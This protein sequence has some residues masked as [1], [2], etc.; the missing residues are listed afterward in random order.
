MCAPQTTTPG[1]RQASP[2]AFSRHLW[3][4]TPHEHRRAAEN[5]PAHR[6]LEPARPRRLPHRRRPTRASRQ[7]LPRPR[8]AGPDAGGRGRHRGPGSAHDLRFPRRARKRRQPRH[9]RRRVRGKTADRTQRRRQPEGHSAHRHCQRPRLARRNAGIAARSLPGLRPAKFRP[10]P[11][12]VRIAG[13]ISSNGSPLALTGI[14]NAFANAANLVD[15]AHAPAVTARSAPLGGNGTVPTQLI[16]SLANSI[17]ACVN[18]AGSTF[19]QCSTLFAN[20]KD[21]AGNPPTDTAAAAINIAHAPGAN[22]STIF[23]LSGPIGTPFTP[24]LGATPPNDF[25]VG[26][27]YNGFDGPY[28]IA[29]DALGNAWVADGDNGNSAANALQKLSSQG[30]LLATYTDPG[31]T[32]ANDVAID[33]NGSAWVAGIDIVRVTASGTLTTLFRSS[34]PTPQSIA[35]D[36]SNNV[37]VSD[38]SPSQLVELN[39]GNGSQDSGSPMSQGSQSADQG[40]VI[41]HSGSPWIFNFTNAS[42]TR[43]T[44]PGTS[45]TGSSFSTGLSGGGATTERAIAVDSSGNVWVAG[46]TSSLATAGTLVEL[47]ASGTVT[48]TYAGAAAGLGPLAAGMAIDG[49]GNIWVGNIT[50]SV[51]EFSSAGAPISPPTAYTGGAQGYSTKLAIDGSGDVWITNIGKKYPNDN[52]TTIVELIGAATPVVTPLSPTYPGK[53]TTGLGTRP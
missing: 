27:T 52:G 17:A 3:D 39:P 30:Q 29:I 9:D 23:N 10:L 15:I 50:G 8:F 19:T 51:S 53:L 45:A 31:L 16:N 37:F 43:I 49:S 48:A 24:N 26:I 28:G 41:D 40:L 7:A 44:S 36:A 33:A 2:L 18:S 6:R 4:Q 1:R 34:L 22:V 11:R 38:N 35:I 46:E 5:H 25:T 13:R 47:N 42:V 14:A 21:F 12:D 20:T 32:Y